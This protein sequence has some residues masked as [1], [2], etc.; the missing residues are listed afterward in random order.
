MNYSFHPAAE[1]EHLETIAYYESQRAGLGANYLAELE[2]L[3]QDI[4]QS[5]QRYPIKK[6][7]GIRHKAMNQFPFAIL[8]QENSEM[9]QILAVAHHRRRPTYWLGR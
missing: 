5:P 9:V 1:A 3:M 7:P 2:R 6:E 4:C 8:Y